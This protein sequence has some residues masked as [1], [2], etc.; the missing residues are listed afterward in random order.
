MPDG[1]SPITYL[2]L[3]FTV[4]EPGVIFEAMQK[5]GERYRG[6]INF[7]VAQSLLREYNMLL[8][9]T[10]TVEEYKPGLSRDNLPEIELALRMIDGPSQ[11]IVGMY[12]QSAKGSEYEKL[13]QIGGCKSIGILTERLLV[14]LLTTFQ[15]DRHYD[16]YTK[17][18]HQR[19]ALAN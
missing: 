2:D 9:S 6:E 11:K 18:M 14:K 5:T 17:I 1:L 13:F 8:L 15:K 16:E 7:S 4:I 19:N 3:G 12:Q 10:G